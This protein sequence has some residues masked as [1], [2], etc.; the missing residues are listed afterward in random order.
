MTITK[1]YCD[2]C[3]KV[4]DEKSDYVDLRIEMCHKAHN[5]DLC[6][7]CFEKLVDTVKEFCK[8]SES[9]GK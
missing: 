5:V 3:G 4:L 7:K 2:H 8:R 9:N 6:T 1:V